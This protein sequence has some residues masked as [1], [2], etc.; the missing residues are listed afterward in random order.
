MSMIVCLRI[1]SDEQLEKLYADPGRVSFF[2]Y[3][4][5]FEMQPAKISFLFKLLSKLMG[6]K[7]VQEEEKKEAVGKKDKWQPPAA[8]DEMDLDKSWHALHFIFTDTAWAGNFPENFLLLGGKEIGS[9]DVGYGPARG[10]KS[11]EVI[12]VNSFLNGIDE[13]YL[14]SKFDPHK[15]TAADIYPNIFTTD[16][17]EPLKYTISYFSTLK[18]F[19]A[20]AAK[21]NKALIIYMN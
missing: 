11:S 15:L 17:N 6:V 10:L 18:K 9:E 12:E 14:E 7:V 20:K 4:D 1:V 2:L 8:G 21:N 19:I 16:D 3:G 5:E 13:I